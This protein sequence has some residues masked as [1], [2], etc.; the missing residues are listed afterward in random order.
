MLEIKTCKFCGKEINVEKYIGDKNREHSCGEC[1]KYCM[2]KCK[3]ALNT[4]IS[5][6]KE[7]CVSCVHNPYKKTHKWNGECWIKC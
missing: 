3:E 1:T 4:N 2:T 6:H 7:P 5:W